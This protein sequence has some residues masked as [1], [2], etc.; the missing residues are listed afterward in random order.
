MF[1]YGDNGD[2]TGSVGGE[3]KSS[4]PLLKA[5]SKPPARIFAGFGDPVVWLVFSAFLLSIC[6]SLLKAIYDSAFKK[7]PEV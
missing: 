3:E 2:I 1:N 6:Y 5:S 4:G 7:K